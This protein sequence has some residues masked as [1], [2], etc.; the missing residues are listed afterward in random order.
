MA[1][2]FNPKTSNNSG[3]DPSVDLAV[4]TQVVSAM[5]KLNAEGKLR[6][7]RTLA[8]YFDISQAGDTRTLRPE[9]VPLPSPALSK[10]STAGFFSEDRSISPKQFIFEKRPQ[11]DIERVTCLAFYI[12]HYRDTP[13]F[14]TLD[15]SKL[16]T[17]AAQIKLSNPNAAVDNATQA[18][19]L[20]QS[21]QGQKQ[22]SAI[23]EL[24]VQALPDRVAAKEAVAKARTRSPRS[25]ARTSPAKK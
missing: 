22:I 2:N 12:T 8:T 5:S 24:Y 15:L 1:L 3:E 11:T 25:K 16:N 23:G 17:E 20:A 18:G 14:K 9:H 4:F 7:F 21:G 13:H 19:L 6:L 10:P